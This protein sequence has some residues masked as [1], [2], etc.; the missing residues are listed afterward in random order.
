MVSLAPI[1]IGLFITY[2]LYL[3]LL[4]VS[5]VQVVAVKH[6]TRAS[7]CTL[8]PF[9]PFLFSNTRHERACAHTNT[10][11]F[12][13]KFVG[14]DEARDREHQ[15]KVSP[16]APLKDCFDLLH[17]ILLFLHFNFWTGD[18]MLLGLFCFSCV[19]FWYTL[20]SG[21]EITYYYHTAIILTSDGIL[22]S[23]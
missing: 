20:A 16:F 14:K 8:K 2:P 19:C 7:M 1:D 12:L 4:D 11:A 5:H 22:L 9:F 3:P 23:Y 17:L 13:S 18:D 21:L 15:T 10:W 6:Q